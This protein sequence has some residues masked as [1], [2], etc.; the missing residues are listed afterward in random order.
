MILKLFTNKF[1]GKV[2]EI[3]SFRAVDFVESFEMWCWKRM[4]KISR[5]DRVNNEVF[6]YRVEGGN[7]TPRCNKKGR[8]EG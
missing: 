7:D 4:E 6:L 8:K 1:L 2:R 3:W 5:N